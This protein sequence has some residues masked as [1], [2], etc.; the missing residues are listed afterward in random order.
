MQRL[1]YPPLHQD[2][3]PIQITNKKK[4]DHNFLYPS[5]RQHKNLPVKIITEDDQSAIVFH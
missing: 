4:S 3:L 1:D 5:D 2:A